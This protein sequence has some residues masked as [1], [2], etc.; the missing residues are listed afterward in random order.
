[1]SHLEHPL[2]EHISAGPLSGK[3]HS[4]YSQVLGK[5]YA[6]C[7]LASSEQPSETLYLFHGGNGNDRQFYEVGLLGLIQGEL[8]ETF[9]KRKIQVV[10]PFIGKSF[11]HHHPTEKQRSYSDFF[12]NEFIPSVE[13]GTGTTSATRWIGGM[14]MGGQAALNA[15]MRKPGLF[16]GV[17]V[18]FPTLV[19]F[20]YA[21]SNEVEA[22]SKRCSVS[23]PFLKTLV[24]EFQNEFVDRQ[25]FLNHDPI[26][27]LRNMGAES[28][29]SLQGK[30]IYFDVGSHDEFGLFEGCD[31]FHRELQQKGIDHCYKNVPDGRHDGPFVFKQFPELLSYLFT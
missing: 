5:E 27:L 26:A 23:D 6:Y 4:F 10:L 18:H 30:R 7:K 31:A 22:F 16:G 15:F 19:C 29:T 9:R 28:R 2:L 13:A 8:A 21:Q 14:S 1:M 12:F 3:R 25:D 17:A 24:E 20:D 11:L